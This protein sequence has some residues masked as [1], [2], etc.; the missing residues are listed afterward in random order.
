MMS[1][2]TIRMVALLLV[3]LIASASTVFTYDVL[4]GT[5]ITDTFVDPEQNSTLD[6]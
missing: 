2:R 5:S 3:I 1:R 4:L 6:Y